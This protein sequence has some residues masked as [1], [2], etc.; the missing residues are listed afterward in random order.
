MLALRRPS[1]QKLHFD[2]QAHDI[3]DL[4]E[5]IG[6]LLGDGG[7]YLD[8]KKKYHI[9]IAFNKKEKQY[10]HYV[11]KLFENYFHPYK[12]HIVELEHEFLVR[13]ISVHVAHHLM[14]NG[15]KEGN[16][17][18]N[19]VTIPNWI[20]SN[21]RYIIRCIRGI[22]DTDGCVYRKFSK[23]AQIQFKFG[24]NGTTSSVHSAVKKLNFLPT[25]I[26]QEKN[27][28]FIHWKFY[29][30]RQ[31]RIASF[32]SIIKP[33]NEKHVRRYHKIITGSGGI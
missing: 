10:L 7:I 23:Y 14:E 2:A 30:I 9:T 6:I 18:T 4:A 3:E 8:Y 12:W 16:K 1:A 5:I 22:F 29:I 19:E 27:G 31:D 26:Q 17:T 24:N 33:Q 20:F 15:L 13:N 25:R 11:K 28:E 21:E 32:F